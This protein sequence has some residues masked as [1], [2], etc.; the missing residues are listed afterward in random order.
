MVIIQKQFCYID[1][2]YIRYK[3]NKL[4]ISILFIHSFTCNLLQKK[5]KKKT[6]DMSNT[7]YGKNVLT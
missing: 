3:L 1:L 6:D 2:I 7:K 4:K 5:K